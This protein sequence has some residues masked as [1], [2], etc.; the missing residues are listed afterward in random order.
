M[1][2]LFTQAKLHEPMEQL[3]IDAPE[4]YLGVITQLMALRKGRMEQM[5]NHGTDH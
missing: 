1:R 5:V 2:D 3:T 4:D